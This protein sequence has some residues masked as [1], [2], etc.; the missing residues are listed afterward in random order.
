MT[1]LRSGS[2]FAFITRSFFR[3][4]SAVSFWFKGNFQMIFIVLVTCYLFD[5]LRVFYSCSLN[6]F[7]TMSSILLTSASNWNSSAFSRTIASAGAAS[8][9]AS[10]RAFTAPIFYFFQFNI[11]EGKLLVWSLLNGADGQ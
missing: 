5:G 4:L 2:F 6:T 1:I 11:Q 8:P 9:A 10:S 3:F 7:T